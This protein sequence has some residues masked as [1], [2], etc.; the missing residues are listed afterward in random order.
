LSHVISVEK[1]SALDGKY[2]LMGNLTTCSEFPSSFCGTF[3]S[4]FP[5]FSPMSRSRSRSP[6]SALE[7][8][9]SWLTA[10]GVWWDDRLRL[11]HLGA[12]GWG[13]TCSKRIEKGEKAGDGGPMVAGVL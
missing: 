2:P 12:S 10:R 13:L 11:Q 7:S 5:S 8:Y 3:L 1:I 4:H 6:H 9:E